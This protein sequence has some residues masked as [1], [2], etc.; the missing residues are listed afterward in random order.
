MS[1]GFRQTGG[2]AAFITALQ[3]ACDELLGRGLPAPG[4]AMRRA[5][6]RPDSPWSWCPGCGSD[7][8]CGGEPRG[9]GCAAGNGPCGALVQAPGGPECVVRLGSHRGLLR[10]WVVDVKHARWASM[11][12]TLGGLLGVQL[13]RCGAA[14]RGDAA[15]VVVPVPMPWL[16][17]RERGIDHALSIASGVSRAL[18]LPLRRALAQRHAGTQVDRLGRDARRSRAERFAARRV[19]R[20]H[21][22]G[23]HVLL[24]DDVRTTG[25]TLEACATLLRSCGASRVTAAVVSVRA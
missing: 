10:D 1:A 5:R 4:D 21:V 17:V 22:A 6:F 2:M 16:R 19:A 24:V 7:R 9:G 23:A 15:T 20:R 11:G 18:G 14:C 8:A 13:G 25:A 3:A 12:E